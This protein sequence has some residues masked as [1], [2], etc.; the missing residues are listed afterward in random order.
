M[1]WNCLDF[2]RQRGVRTGGLTAWECLRGNY[3]ENSGKK[4]IDA[5]LKGKCDTPC[6]CLFPP[7]TE[8]KT[9]RP[10]NITIVMRKVSVWKIPFYVCLQLLFGPMFSLM[11]LHFGGK[12]STPV[13]YCSFFKCFVPLE[14]QFAP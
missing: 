4:S 3:F 14:M 12:V 6:F 13:V 11:F 7:L 9:I 8:T 5:N 1:K 2:A 10:K